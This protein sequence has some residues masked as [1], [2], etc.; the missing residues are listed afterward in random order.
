[1]RLPSPPREESLSARCDLTRR[2]STRS[3]SRQS[4][5]HASEIAAGRASVSALRARRRE[6]VKGRARRGGESRGLGRIAGAP[7]AARGDLVPRDADRRGDAVAK[8]T[9]KLDADQKTQRPSQ[10]ANEIVGRAQAAVDRGD[11]DVA[12]NLPQGSRGLRVPA[13][14]SSAGRARGSTASRRPPR[15]ALLETCGAARA[16]DLRPQ[17][18]P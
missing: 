11:L 18:R 14:P 15:H 3:M 12:A 6:G 1:V 9:A 10:R 17:N 2:P 13:G 8:L 16:R 4:V 5:A 7:A